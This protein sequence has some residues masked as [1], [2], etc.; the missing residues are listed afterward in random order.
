[1]YIQNIKVDVIKRL[2]FLIDTIYVEFSGHIFQQL[3]GIS[4]DTNQAPLLADLFSNGYE[5][6]FIQGLLKPGKK[7]NAKKF[8]FTYKYIDDVLS[9]NNLKLSEFIG[10]I[11][12][13]NL[14]LKLRQS[15]VHLP[16]IRL[17]Y[18]Y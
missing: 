2:E 4:T 7:H 15:P 18:L 13:V 12:H 10:L 14:K 8:N 3:V 5:A 17:I 11:Y 6:E 16:Q 1:M 9:L